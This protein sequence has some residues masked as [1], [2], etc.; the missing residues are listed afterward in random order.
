MVHNIS[1]SPRFPGYFQGISFIKKPI[2]FRVFGRVRSVTLSSVFSNSK[3]SQSSHCWVSATKR[4]GSGDVCKRPRTP[5]RMYRRGKEWLNV[6]E[7][8]KQFPI[9]NWDCWMPCKWEISWQVFFH[10]YVSTW[11]QERID[12]STQITVMFGIAQVRDLVVK[13]FAKIRRPRIQW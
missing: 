4:P 3:S 8:K 9:D 6:N 11:V 13:S 7:F 5:Y 2:E 1:P 12:S 10:I